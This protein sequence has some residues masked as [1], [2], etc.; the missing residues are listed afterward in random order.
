VE[1]ILPPATLGG[2]LAHQ[3]ALANL[4][5]AVFN[6]LPG[7]P[8]DG[9]RALQAG[10]WALTGDRNRGQRA[11][12]WAGRAIAGASLL[13]AL[14]LYANQSISTI[15]MVVLLLVAFT[16]WTGA[17]QAVSAGVVA[18]RVAGI[19]VARLVR[20]VVAVAQGT[21]L[22]QARLRAEASGLPDPVIV[23]A[24][25]Y[26]QVVGLVHPQAA[27][28]VPGERRSWVA[29]DDLTR[30]IGPEHVIAAGLRGLDLLRVVGADPSADYLVVEDEDVIGVVR[31]ADLTTLLESEGL[32]SRRTTR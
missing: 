25:P 31:G 27:A 24:D 11:A 6:A 3:L 4:I 29:V 20:P 7:L 19:E 5:V 9:G 23:V 12:G 22:A 8:L 2:E 1:L 28:A 32:V 30:R 26:G 14:G 17:G 13:V 10:I 15:G 21:P 16:I 18:D